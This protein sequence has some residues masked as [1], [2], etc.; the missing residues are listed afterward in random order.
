MAPGKLPY[1]IAN[2]STSFPFRYLSRIY[3]SFASIGWPSKTLVR[4][5]LLG[6]GKFVFDCCLAVARRFG[7][8][9]GSAAGEPADMNWLVRLFPSF[10]AAE[11]SRAGCLICVTL[12]IESCIGDC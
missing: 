12:Y 10:L 3:V 4:E 8:A 5:G 7:A 6:D 9:F 11:L 2:G 1:S